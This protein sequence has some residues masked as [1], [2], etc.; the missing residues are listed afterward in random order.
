MLQQILKVET[1]IFYILAVEML[2]LILLQFRTNGLLKRTYKMRVQ[3][4]ENVRQLKEEVK[5]GTSD[6]PVVKFEKQKR[7]AESQ[8]KPEKKSGYDMNEMAV[9]QEMMSEFFG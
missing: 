9:L 1:L 8:K 6:I 2:V 5:G 3:K 7:G 4:K